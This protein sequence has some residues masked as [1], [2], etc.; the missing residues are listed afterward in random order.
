MDYKL[1]FIIDDSGS[2][3]QDSDVLMASTS[4]YLRAKRDPGHTRKHCTRWEEVEDRLHVMMDMLAYIPTGMIT[5]CFLNR[6]DVFEYSHEGNTPKEFKSVMHEK[7]TSLFDKITNNNTPLYRRLSESLSHASGKTMHYV[8]TDGVPSDASIDVIQK[9]VATR[10]KPQDNPITFISCTDAD[11][12][13]EWMKS[14]EETAPFCAELDDFEDEKAEVLKDQG[15][16][17]PY[18][19]GLWLISQ[20]VAAINPDDLDAIDES[21]PFTRGTLGNMLGR[22]LTSAEYAHYFNLNPNKGKYQHLYAQFERAD[23]IARD[24][25]KAHH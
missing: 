6:S 9:L 21:M 12:E 7:I 8:M 5:L 23:L 20:L 18:T 25:V 24:I 10:A 22:D 19:K 2:M 1:R 11:D 17:F 3:Q 4:E 16:A 13:T 15:P 14:I